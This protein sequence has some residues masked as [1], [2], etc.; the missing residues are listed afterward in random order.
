MIQIMGVFLAGLVVA[1][2]IGEAHAMPRRP[3]NVHDPDDREW[4][5]KELVP[6]V[7]KLSPEP[8][9]RGGVWRRPFKVEI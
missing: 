6:T 9:E 2:I 4:G 1:A 8:L 7:P 5:R 3:E